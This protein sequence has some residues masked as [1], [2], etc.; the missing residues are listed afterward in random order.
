MEELLKRADNYINAKE[1]MAA[2]EISE[3]VHG[4]KAK[5]ESSRRNRGRGQKRKRKEELSKENLSHKL[6]KMDQER[7]SSPL[8]LYE[9]YTPLR[10]SR[11]NILME[12]KDQHTLKWPE[13][14]RT[15]LERRDKSKYCRFHRDH[16]HN[17]DDCRELMNQI[18]KLIQRGHLKQY[19]KKDDYKGQSEKKRDERRNERSREKKKKE[20]Q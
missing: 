17:T 14:M 20:T 6:D 3:S 10:D 2:R 12:I 4:S 7:N 13:E 16:G 1:A 5:E 11:A 9:K 15:P 8:P 19:V 18:E